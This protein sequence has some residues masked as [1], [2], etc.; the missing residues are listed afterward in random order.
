MTALVNAINLNPQARAILAHLA[1]GQNINQ[2]LALNAYGV[3]RLSERIREIKAAGYN[4]ETRYER[5]GSHRNLAIY[6]MAAA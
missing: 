6:S 4:I 2:L 5:R 1:A 3:M